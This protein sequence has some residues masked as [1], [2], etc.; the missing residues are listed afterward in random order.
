MWL[1]LCEGRITEREYFNALRRAAA[2]RAQVRIEY[3]PGGLPKLVDEARRRLNRDNAPDKVWCIADVDDFT[4]AQIRRAIERSAAS[5]EIALAI[6]NPCFELWALL[7]F[8][9]CQRFL[10]QEQAK[11]RLKRHLST[12]EKHLPFELL[13]PRLFE[14][15]QRAK[16]LAL[17]GD[18]QGR[19]N[20]STGVH[21]LVESLLPL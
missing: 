6:S 10:T 7:H 21:L 12:Y 9:D 3:C 20:P 14:A 2:L 18:A 11:R 19:Y 8:E 13:A 4:P 17:R 16:A 15:I 1:L 5:P